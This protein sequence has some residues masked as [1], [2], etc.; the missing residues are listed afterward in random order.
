MYIPINIHT[1]LYIFIYYIRRPPDLLE[2][3]K[4]VY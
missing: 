4:V 1:Y 2:A 3:T